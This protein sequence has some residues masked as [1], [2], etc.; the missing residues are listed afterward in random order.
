MTTGRTSVGGF[1]RRGFEADIG[2]VHGFLANRL[3]SRISM[4]L[5]IFEVVGHP[6]NLI[7]PLFQQRQGI[8]LRASPFFL[9]SS[10][11]LTATGCQSCN[12]VDRRIPGTLGTFEFDI[13]RF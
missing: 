12:F 1:A 8:Y 6:S 2:I 7:D 9:N 5:V 3:S 4:I 13:H 11:A 10:I